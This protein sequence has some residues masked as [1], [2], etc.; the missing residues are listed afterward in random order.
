MSDNTVTKTYEAHNLIAEEHRE[1]D[2]SQTQR[3]L[4]NGGVAAPPV[5]CPTCRRHP[6]FRG[7]ER[8]KTKT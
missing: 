8:K 4:R 5:A 7:F 3:S 6:H 2:S 1:R